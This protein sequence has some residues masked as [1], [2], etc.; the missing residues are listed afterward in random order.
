MYADLHHVLSRIRAS[1]FRAVDLAAFEDWQNVNPSF[2]LADDGSWGDAIAD[3]LKTVGLQVSSINAGPSVAINDPNHASFVRYRQEVVALLDLAEKLA[4][5]NVTL[6]PGRP[7][8][9]ERDAVAFD[10]TQAH[11]AELGP[12][13]GA[14]NVTLSIEGH[15]GSL[16]E[17]PDAALR[18]MEAL[19]PSVGFTYDPSHWA[20]QRISLIETERLLRYTYHVHVRNAKP[21]AMQASMGEGTVDFEWLIQALRECEYTGAV[22]IEYFN[23]FD[24]DLQETRALRDYLLAQGVEP[25]PGGQF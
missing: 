21:S 1:G 3:T 13:A 12:L 11:L 4:C 24:A 14:R 19:W 20:M 5:P 6:Q 9:G 10:R 2:L 7:I 16:L 23:G 18:M 8:F 25:A 17:R 15:Q 22:S